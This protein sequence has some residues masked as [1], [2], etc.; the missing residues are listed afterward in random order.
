MTTWPPHITVAAIIED[1]KKFL[2]VQERDDGR[3]VYNQPAGHLEQEET[4]VQASMRE[5]LEETS[6]HY[7]PS[8][9]IGI[10]FYKANNGITYQRVCFTGKAIWQ[11][12][13]RALDTDIVQAVWLSLEEIY[14]RISQLRSP[15]V[16]QCINDY[17]TGIRYPLQLIHDLR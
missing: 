5:T 7:Q 6:W 12:V 13:D 10:Y 3:I 16:L 8:A 9:L 2:L 4:L 17:L 11:E 14:A 1:N 15:M